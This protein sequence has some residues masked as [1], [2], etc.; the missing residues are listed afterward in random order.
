MIA[1]W[2]DI[3]GTLLDTG[4]SGG[5]AFKQALRRQYQLDDD[6]DYIRFAGATDLQIVH[7]VFKHIF[8]SP[9]EDIQRFLIPSIRSTKQHSPRLH[10]AYLK[11]RVTSL[12]PYLG[13]MR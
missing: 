3:G 8:S 1:V 4:G 6:M 7:D 5:N 2:F 11:A 10:R 12:K 9:P 13:T